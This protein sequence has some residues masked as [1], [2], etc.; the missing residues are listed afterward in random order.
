[1]KNL[2]EII[3]AIRRVSLV[4]LIAPATGMATS[5]T[6]DAG[7]AGPLPFGGTYAE[8]GMVVTSYSDNAQIGTPLGVNPTG[9]GLYFHG[10]DQYVEFAMV[11]GSTFD[12][13]SFDFLTN[14][15]TDN[16]WVEA[17]SGAFQYL[18]GVVD[19]QTFTFAGTGFQ[20][21]EWFRVGTPWFATEMDN[22]NFTSSEPSPVPEPAT[23]TLMSV[24]LAGIG[25][26]KRR[27]LT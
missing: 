6:F 4:L 3:N 11:D 10:V 8:N 16:R 19:W 21:I 5:M 27:K 22:V 7:P 15:F 17:S 26:G 1:M 14:G 20:S 9:N 24:G 25:F 13:N 23:F 18:P 12:L 2:T